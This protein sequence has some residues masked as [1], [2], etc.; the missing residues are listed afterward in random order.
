MDKFPVIYN[1]KEGDLVATVAPACSK[2]PRNEIGKILKQYSNGMY[3][4]VL[5]C[6]DTIIYEN[7]PHYFLRP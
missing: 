6:S 1:F 3:K 7:V 2:L 4:I 5:N